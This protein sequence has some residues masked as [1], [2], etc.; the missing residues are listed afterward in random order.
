ML[1]EL[2]DGPELTAGLH[3]LTEAKDCFVRQ[4]LAD[5]DPEE[6]N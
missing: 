4:S 6:W 1:D 5:S 3:K 2:D